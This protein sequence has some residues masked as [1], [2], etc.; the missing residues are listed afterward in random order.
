MTKRTRTLLFF[1]CSFCFLII[2]PLVVFYNQG[3]R[4]DLTTY[5]IT[6]TGALYFRV[7]PRDSEVLLDG[8][9]MKKTDFFFGSALIENLLPGNYSVEIRKEGYSPWRKNL[10]V[11]AM[12][13]TEAN[14]VVL[15]PEKNDFAIFAKGVEKFFPSPS[16]RKT[17]LQKRDSQGQYLTLFD[18]QSNIE[19]IFLRDRS[20]ASKAAAVS[21]LDLQWSAD[22]Q[23]ILIRTVVNE[24]ER[25]FW[26]DTQADPA[27]PVALDLLNG[28]EKVSFSTGSNPGRQFLGLKEQALFFADLDSRKTQKIMDHVLAFQSFE[29]KIYLLDNTGIVSR[30]D[31]PL[32][33]EKQP[34]SDTPFPTR[35]EVPLELL[36]SPSNL[37]LR[38][39]N[40]LYR[41]DEKTRSLVKIVDSLNDFQVSP[42]GEKLVYLNHGEISVYFLKEKTD[43]P[44]KKAGERILLARFS[45]DIDRAYWLNNNYLIFSVG[46]S[47][48]IGEIDDRPALNVREIAQFKNPLLFFQKSGDNKKASVLTEGNFLLSANLLP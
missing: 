15:F 34:L 24:G 33:T 17:I 32:A 46:E 20:F 37:F 3:Y 26:A 31:N 45:Q 19:K 16:G 29:G 6:K 48:R 7:S 9:L 5:R 21:F 4:F 30:L 39:E 2:T 11:K 38:E 14:N 41:L 13:V 25:L 42:D 23:K 12:A 22:S 18:A 28:F 1:F 27:S 36:V 43:Q 47:L 35:S 10:E 40:S 44:Q 8:R